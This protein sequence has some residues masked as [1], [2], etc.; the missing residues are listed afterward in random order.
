MCL[1]MKSWINYFLVGRFHLT[2]CCCSFSPF[3]LPS[4]QKTWFPKQRLELGDF[5]GLFKKQQLYNL[6]PYRA[7]V[8]VFF[9]PHVL[10]CARRD[11]FCLKCLPLTTALYEK[12]PPLRDVQ[13]HFLPPKF[14]RRKFNKIKHV[15]SKRN[16]SRF[17]E[18][19][20]LVG[21]W[22]FYWV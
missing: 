7:V 19:V 20:L 2:F 1:Q 8:L 5:W 6:P 13:A 4:C 17:Y 14:V 12:S 16:D 22:Y 15:N 3:F 10:P 18:I 21:K 9:F 11:L